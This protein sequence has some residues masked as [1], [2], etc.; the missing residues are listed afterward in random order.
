MQ[1]LPVTPSNFSS[2]VAV[3]TPEGRREERDEQ[4]DA[5]EHELGSPIRAGGTLDQMKELAAEAR[6]DRKVLDLEITNSSLEAINRTLERQMRKQNAELRRYKRLSRSGRLSLANPI[7]SGEYSIMR[8]MD[9]AD[10]SDM[11]EGEEEDDEDREDNTSEEDSMDD[12]SLSPGAMAESDARHR[13]KDEKRLRLDLS[14]HQQLIADSQSMN[15]SLRRCLAWTEE[16]IT[17]GKKALAYSVR[18]SDV[19]IGGRVLISEDIEIDE[20]EGLSE[21]GAR[22]VRE[23]RRKRQSSLSPSASSF[24]GSNRGDSWADKADRDSGIELPN[25][26]RPEPS[27]PYNNITMAHLPS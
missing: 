21:I 5:E 15:S 4:R 8:G 3:S 24:G 2:I 6:R 12:G 23:A 26:Y 11:S 20:S 16:L 17:E 7:S 13:Q 25:N 27:S 19:N 10:L 1:T 9:G 18:P 22:L 14:R